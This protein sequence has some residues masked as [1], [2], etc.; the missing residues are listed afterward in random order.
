MVIGSG[1]AM[2]GMYTYDTVLARDSDKQEGK[3]ADRAD[4]SVLGDPCL[5]YNV[6]GD[7]ATC[8]DGSFT[9]I[10]PQSPIFPNGPMSGGTPPAWGDIGR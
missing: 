9:P 2:A 8:A 6:I 3:R 1:L 7:I 4:S 5:D 10:A